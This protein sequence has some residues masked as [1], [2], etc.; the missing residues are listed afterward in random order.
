MLPN[1]QLSDI[2]LK[3]TDTTLDLSQKAEKAKR[4]MNNFPSVPSEDPLYPAND[5]EPRYPRQQ[6]RIEAL[7]AACINNGLESPDCSLE[8][9]QS[10]TE[11]DN[12]THTHT[13]N[14]QNH[15]HNTTHNRGHGQAWWRVACWTSW[16]V[17]CS[18]IFNG[19]E[20]VVLPA[21]LRRLRPLR[22]SLYM[23]VISGIGCFAQIAGLAAGF[24]SDRHTS[25][26][27]KRTPYV[28]LACALVVIGCL[29]MYIAHYLNSVLLISSGFL[30]QVSGLSIG[31]ISVHTLVPDL[32]PTS[33]HGMSSGLLGTHSI[34]GTAVGYVAFITGIGVAS[35][36]WLYIG[37]VLIFTALTVLCAQERKYTLHVVEKAA[38]IKPTTSALHF[39][40]ESAKSSWA[41]ITQHKN[42]AYLLCM[43]F[44]FYCHVAFLSY[45]QYWLADVIHTS[46]PES[47]M[48]KVGLILLCG[49]LV[50]ALPAGKLS[51]YT[52]RRPLLGF[53]IFTMIF[54]L[55]A[56]IFVSTEFYAYAIAFIYG[57][58]SGIYYTLEDAVAFDFLPNK[59]NSGKFMSEFGIS[60]IVGELSG[61]VFNGI[62][63][64]FFPSA[65]GEYSLRGYQ[66]LFGAA[67]L[68]LVLT[69]AFICA[70]R[71]RPLDSSATTTTPSEA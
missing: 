25:K 36:N 70:M 12:D 6:P 33:Q 20:G 45:L 14:E 47:A 16:M 42:F 71:E 7:S 2:K 52:G 39:F 29:A 67:G 69:L 41:L 57:I 22:S 21:E 24:A 27:G 65:V 60:S 61:L 64:D 17:P 50:T 18:A 58:S 32:L 44:F 62:L 31:E 23:G 40:V 56:L 28:G 55:L 34:I 63:L 43:R 59:E 9:H 4:L 19:V 30:L 15:H 1:G 49:A 8:L 35:V 26:W 37:G 66:T 3:R 53:S 10:H 11:N 46:D 13:P 68:F 38:H 48:G 5:E 54:C 51:D